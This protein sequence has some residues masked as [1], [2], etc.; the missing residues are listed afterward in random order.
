MQEK[1][2]LYSATRTF[3]QAPR[4]PTGRRALSLEPG[5]SHYA[6]EA[7]FIN[8]RRPPS[9]PMSR[10][11]GPAH[12]F[13]PADI[14]R[15]RERGRARFSVDDD[16]LER[17]HPLDSDSR[18]TPGLSSPSLASSEDDNSVPSLR[19]AVHHLHAHPPHT[20]SLPVLERQ[21]ATISPLPTIDSPYE[22]RSLSRTLPA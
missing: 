15:G 9:P 12:Q 1:I 10:D 21:S 3:F 8:R 11:P 7:E 13:S 14:P 6:D 18:S 17:V 22:N 2:N 5:L 16:I 19:T 4:I 20:S